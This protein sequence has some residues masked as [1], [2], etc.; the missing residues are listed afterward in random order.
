[1]SPRVNRAPHQVI[2]YAPA[3]R[4]ARRLGASARILEVG[5]GREGIGTW[6]RRSFV[7]VDLSFA[8]PPAARLLAVRADACRLPFADA[9]FDV[10][11]C[12]DVVQDL[13]K[14]LV[15]AVC[16]ELA[17]VAHGLVVLVV[18]C[19]TAAEA[20]DAELVTWCRVHGIEPPEWLTAQF[21]SGLP[22]P[23]DIA[24]ALSR[25]GRLVCAGNTSVRW[26]ERMF[27]WEHRMQ[28]WHVMTLA[29]PVLRAWGRNAPFEL[30]GRNGTYR[31]SFTLETHA[32]SSPP[33]RAP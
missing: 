11:V 15:S 3:L 24:A 17:R 9:T 33:R 21:R 26:H 27:R 4:L 20:S 12:V 1:M 8:G 19:G 16:D 23:G 13:P 22:A 5:S 25:H 29:Q 10:V 6:L 14:S 32:T 30:P 28:R 2:R 7:G 31:F 18:P